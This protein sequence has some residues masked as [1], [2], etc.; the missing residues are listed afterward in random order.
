MFVDTYDKGRYHTYMHPLVKAIPDCDLLLS[1]EPEELAA[2]LLFAGVPLGSLQNFLLS[3]WDRSYIP[4]EQSGSYPSNRRDEIELALTEAWSWLEAQGLLVRVP[5]KF[6][7]L[8]RRA[9]KI[10]TSADFANFRV[11]RLLQ[12]ETLH[13]R[14]ADIVWG[15]FMR[16]LF[17]SAAFHAMKA[18]EVSVRETAGLGNNLVGVPLMREAFAA[19]RGVL[20][21]TSVERGEQVAR[22]ELFAGA[23]GCYKNPQSHRDVN[24]ENPFEALEIILLA[25]HLLRVVDARAKAKAATP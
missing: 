13:P 11:S 3:L 17:D 4:G 18:V 2:K 24:L 15:D 16:G 6:Q 8:S 1:L 5:N 14:I 25:N 9:Q 19:D 21:D 10:K 12:K 7:T 22:M 23:I 20:T